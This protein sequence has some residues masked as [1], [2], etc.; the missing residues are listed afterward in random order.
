MT[1]IL[2]VVVTLVVFLGVDFFGLSYIIK[3]VFERHIG[4]LLSDSP[5]LFPAF[6]FYVFFISTVV[7]FVSW[8]AIQN[9]HSLTWVF[10]HAA[11]LGAMGYGT[12]EFT[13]LAVMK[14]WTWNMV[15]AD[16]SWG[17][18][19]TGASACAGVAILRMFS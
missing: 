7:Y 6:L 10:F 18:V 11:L 9:E 13:S 2:L 15:A 17:T 19:L 3:P 14:D 1:A 8:P 4:H 5:R 16:L 12:Y